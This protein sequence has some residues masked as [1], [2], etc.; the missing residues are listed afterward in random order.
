MNTATLDSNIYIS[1]L[2][3]GGA[4]ARS[5][6]MARAGIFRLD[7][8]EAILDETIGVL[9]DKF[10]WDGYSLQDVRQKMLKIANRVE[11]DGTVNASKDDPD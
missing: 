7:V 3:F 10:E 1:A 4:G 5:L 8:S 6:G 11:P 9:R 2:Q